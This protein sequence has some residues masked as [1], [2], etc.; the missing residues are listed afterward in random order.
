MPGVYG[1]ATLKKSP[2]A[3]EL[4]KGVIRNS[5]EKPERGKFVFPLDSHIFI[6]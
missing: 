2:L 4:E 5:W 6:L 1:L 3:P